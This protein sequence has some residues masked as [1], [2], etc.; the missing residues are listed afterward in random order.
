M[1]NRIKQA[2]GFAAAHQVEFLAGPAAPRG[3]FET[4]P[5]LDYGRLVR[6]EPAYILTP[7]TVESLQATLRFL[8]A[9]SQPYKVRGA[10]HSSSGEVLSDGG[11]IVDL[12]QLSATLGSDPVAGTV[13]VQ[14]GATWLSVIERLAQPRRRSFVRWRSRLWKRAA[15]STWRLSRCRR[16]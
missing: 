2:I 15:T 11:A 6:R 10:A 5:A 12:R 9:E 7:S 16:L 13:Q 4:D 1:E 3:H 8:R 14:A